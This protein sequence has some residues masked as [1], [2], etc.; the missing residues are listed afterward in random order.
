MLWLNQ[1]QMGDIR[2]HAEEGF[3]HEICG[4]LLGTVDRP[5]GAPPE[6]AVRIV[7]EIVPAANLNT[8]RAADRYDLDPKTQI[9]AERKARKEGWE[10]LGFYHSHPDHPCAASA[11]DFERSWDGYSYLIMSVVGGKA[12]DSACWIRNP[13]ERD[14][15]FVEES[16][17]VS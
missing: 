8:Q 4:I 1:V 7:R 13:D 10:V 2:R 15:Y 12:A 5:E 16:V 17:T 3:P 6:K 9:Q 14:D 11:T